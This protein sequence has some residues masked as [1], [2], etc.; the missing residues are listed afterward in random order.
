MLEDVFHLNVTFPSRQVAEWLAELRHVLGRLH[1]LG[2]HGPGRLAGRLSRL[3]AFVIR[4]QRVAARSRL[5]KLV[6]L[7]GLQME[8]RSTV[9]LGFWLVTP[10][11]R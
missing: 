5:C 11:R 7:F 9:R 3:A 6:T 1:R 4:R 8:R 10:R 2:C